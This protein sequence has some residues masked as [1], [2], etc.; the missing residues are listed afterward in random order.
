MPR[1]KEF[2]LEQIARA[3]RFALAMNT[4]ADRQRFE[5]M[6]AD[7]QNELEGAE[8]AEGQSS[9]A[10]EDA[11]PTDDAVSNQPQTGGSDAATPASTDNQEPTTD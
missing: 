10:S 7:L 4:E 6:A 3:K 5:K 1:N 11:V 8:G 9:N 2:L